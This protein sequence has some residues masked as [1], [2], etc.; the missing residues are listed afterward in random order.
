MN[1]HCTIS[2][3]VLAIVAISILFK[4]D[5]LAGPKGD[6]IVRYLGD[7][8]ITID[9]SIS[10][11]PLDKFKKV[12][13]QPNFPAA[14]ESDSTDASGDHIVFDRDRIGRFNGTGENAWQANDSDFGSTI[15]FAYNDKYL[16]IL[17]VCIDDVY[18]ME[19]DTSEYGATGFFNDGFE[20]FLD[21]LN[22]SDDCASDIAFPNFDPEAPNVDD[23]QVTVSLN[24]NFKPDDSGDDVFGVRQ[25]LERGG[26]PE[27][28]GPDKGGPGGIYRDALDTVPGGDIAAKQYEDLRAAGARNPEILANPNVTYSGYTVEMLIP[29]GK[30]TGFTPDHSM[31]FELFWRDVDTD[32][33]EGKGGANISW[34]SWAQSTTVDCG[35]PQTSLFHTGNWGELIFDTP[36]T[37]GGQTEN[38]ISKGDIIV[39]HLGNIDIDID[40][41][42]SDWPLDKF[43]KVAEQPNFPAAQ[44]SDSTDASGD[45]IV[46]DRDRIGRFNGTGE[47][48]WQANDSDFG[49][50]IYFAHND[51]YL[52]ILAV[53]IDDVY[54]MERDTSE[55]GAT[56]FFNDG[57]EFFLDALNDSDDCASDIAFPNFDPEAPNVDDFQV[58]VSLNEN[59]KPDDSGDDVFGV[60][61]TLERGGDPELN[62]PD[63][64][65]P[66]GIYRDALDTVPGGDIAAKQYE[67]LRAAGARNPEILANPNVTY[68][69][70][71]VE[72]LIPFGK[73]TGFTPD[74]SMGFELFWRDV[75]TDDD[76]GKGGANISWAS[77]AQS[78]TVD[79]GDP[80]TSLF[81]TGNW[82]ELIFDTANPLG[83]VVGAPAGDSISIARTGSQVTLQWNGDLEA[84]QKV[85]GPWSAIQATSP[86]AFSPSEPSQYY[87]GVQA[88][89]VDQ[90]VMEPLF[91]DDLESGA[92]GW[93][94]KAIGEVLEEDAVDPWQ[95]GAPVSEDYGPTKA[96]SGNNVWGTNLEDYYPD[97]CNGSLRTPPID[98]TGA[99]A[100]TLYFTE[101]MDIE[102]TPDDWE[103]IDEARINILDASDPDGEPIEEDLRFRSG[104]VLGWATRRIPLPETALGKKILIEFRFTSD[105]GPYGDFGDQGGWY[106][107]DIMVLPE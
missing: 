90:P 2:N 81:H 60:R 63:K 92:A 82:G 93:T 102:V 103:V 37:L 9:G 26:D 16:Y 12:A 53:C 22:D 4:S 84:A 25:T 62:G 29:F 96:W 55:Y 66:G 11:W 45:H 98:L 49:S 104:R 71:T 30:I 77:W 88:V 75:D 14:Q 24:E 85:T 83:D 80:K 72:M 39:R 52:Y 100:A 28:N 105:D 35:D 74:H 50:T 15:Y 48:A 51:E 20:F 43:E 36:S 5:V 13:E 46:F 68:S 86:L 32:D 76:E 61:Q 33:D 47:N 34:A 54:R 73:I 99:E 57:F 95:L 69:G 89:I 65:G 1:S 64:G 91:S 70:Y 58:T 41:S 97:Y 59:F 56:G 19:R 8:N 44:E 21:A 31:G 7:E 27:L 42:V 17:A 67:D 18:R 10:D 101:F 6:I 23:F 78:T 87:R 94:H 107:D 79:C 3:L 40:G 106:I 38:T